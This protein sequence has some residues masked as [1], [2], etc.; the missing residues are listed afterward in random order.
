MKK[1]IT[2]LL[3]VVLCFTCLSACEGWRESD[4]VAYNISKEA[5]NFNVTRRLTVFNIRTDTVLMQMTGKFAIKNEGHDELSV[6]VEVEKGTYQKHFVYLND[7]TMYTVEDLSGADVSPYSY[8]LEFLP[9]MLKPVK[10]T[11]HELVEDFG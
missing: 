4:R 6:I 3:V 9:Q 11:A 8:E 10:I 1:L 5:D 2:L 7:Y